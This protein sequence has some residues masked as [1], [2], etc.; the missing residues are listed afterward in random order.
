[1]FSILFEELFKLF[2]LVFEEPG[3]LLRAILDHLFH[4]Q[5]V[6]LSGDPLVHKGSVVLEHLL[7]YLARCVRD[8]LEAC[9]E[10][11]VSIF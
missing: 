5:S 10:Y 6:L 7:R 9:P 4:S 3:V 11:K 8:L 2:L 1:M